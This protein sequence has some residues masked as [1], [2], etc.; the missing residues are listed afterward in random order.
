[1][2]FKNDCKKSISSKKDES[3]GSDVRH[4]AEDAVQ[5]DVELRDGNHD[6]TDSELDGETFARA[7]GRLQTG[8]LP[9]SAQGIRKYC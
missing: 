4:D 7:T 6:Q 2:I 8:L 3:L 1:M 9:R 5:F